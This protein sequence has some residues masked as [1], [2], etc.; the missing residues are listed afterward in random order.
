MCAADDNYVKPLAVMLQSAA[1]N[2][3]VGNQLQVIV[4]DG[5]I[6]EA[7]WSGLKETL[8][9][10]PIELF[11]IR[12][13]I[14][15]VSDLATSHHITHTAYLRLL[16]GRI[17][18]DS[19]DKVI[20]LDSDLLICD[21]LS[22]LWEL[23][24]GD[25]FALAVPDV[26]CP[27][28][29]ARYAKSN[30]AKSSPYMAAISPIANWQ[31]LGIAPHAPYFNSGVMVLNIKRMRDEKIEHRLLE[32][33]KQNQK[34]VWCWDQYALNVVFSDS[35]TALPLK[36]NQGAHVFEFPDKTYSPMNEDEFLL[37]RDKP[38]IIHYTTE[39][40]PWRYGNN[41]PLKQKYFDQLDQTV[42]TG[43]RPTKPS[44]SLA[45]SWQEFATAFVKQWTI[46]YRKLSGMFYSSDRYSAPT[47]SSE[48][49][50]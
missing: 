32:C 50:S 2:V 34:F 8:A 30:F 18:P 21:D 19:I 16:A 28:V 41:H 14:A 15:A 38:S 47:S 17:L 12:P 23:P 24:L 49:G 22:E 27:Y 29:D 4:L 13:D 25:Q 26:A 42:W 40:K 37:A 20:Y 31:E 7:N 9:D 36:W 1:Q 3:R 39:W 33:L 5:G 10:L 46:G 11:S 45:R 48:S 35:W 43:W 44:F 6:S